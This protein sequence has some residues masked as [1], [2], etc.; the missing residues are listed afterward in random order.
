M[1]NRWSFGIH[2]LFWGK[3][4][5]SAWQKARGVPGLGRLGTETREIG[6][7][8]VSIGG[9]PRLFTQVKSTGEF[10]LLYDNWASA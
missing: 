4:E 8:M 7:Y 2:W 5:P 3:N 9:E 1:H 6:C 10:A